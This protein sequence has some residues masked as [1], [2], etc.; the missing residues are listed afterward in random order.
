MKKI[1]LLTCV[2]ISVLATVTTSCSN[3][4]DA[5][6][7]TPIAVAN[8]FTY[9]GVT[10]ALSQGFLED[11]GDNGNGS[12]D[13]DITLLSDDF[14][15]DTVN[16]SITGTGEAVYLDLNSDNMTD[17]SDGTYIFAANRD[18]FT[19]VVAGI[20]IDYNITAETGTLVKATG[21]EVILSKLGTTYTIIFDLTTAAGDITGRYEGTLTRL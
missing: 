3:D 12:Y 18:A 6:D 15:L 19:L 11:Y 20:F 14:T 16:Q 9:D 17:L 4:D 8:E 7:D 5:V 10:Y 13:F 2:F 1:K 21:G